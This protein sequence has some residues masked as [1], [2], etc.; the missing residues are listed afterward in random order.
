MTLTAFAVE[1]PLGGGSGKGSAR[2]LGAV[3]AMFAG[4]LVGALLLKTS[5]ALPLA[6]AAALA[7]IAGIAYVPR[8]LRGG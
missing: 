3:L 5:M 2:R 8:A 6:L 1:S 7:L 4:A